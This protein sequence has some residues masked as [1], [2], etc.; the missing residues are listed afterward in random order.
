[1]FLQAVLDHTIGMG[2]MTVC[3]A[4]SQEEPQLA[5]N[6]HKK[7]LKGAASGLA[8]DSLQVMQMASPSSAAT[9]IPLA[10]EDIAE[11]EHEAQLAKWQEEYRAHREATMKPDRL[12][13]VN[14]GGQRVALFGRRVGSSR[15][16]AFQSGSEAA[17]FLHTNQGEISKAKTCRVTVPCRKSGID[18]EFKGHGHVQKPLQQGKKWSAQRQRVSSKRKRG[19]LDNAD[20]KENI[21]ER[22][23]KVKVLEFR[24]R[25]FRYQVDGHGW[26]PWYK[27]RK[28]RAPVQFQD[29]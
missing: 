8:A 19:F 13:A 14:S 3:M 29:E 11:A 21:T 16:L 12:K 6:A 20:E 5:S 17:S 18:W 26:V 25:D 1:M 9:A 27:L 28:Q 15:W 7:T 22:W 23:C 2:K 4:A 24:L 10:A